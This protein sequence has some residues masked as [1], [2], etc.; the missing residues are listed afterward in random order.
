MKP[1]TSPRTT[2]SQ[3]LRERAAMAQAGRRPPAASRRRRHP[4][5]RGSGC[6]GFGRGSPARPRWPRRLHCSRG[7]LL[8]AGGDVGGGALAASP[9]L[10]W[11]L[12]TAA[13][14]PSPPLLPLSLLHTAAA[15]ACRS[16]TFLRG[17]RAPHSGGRRCPVRTGEVTAPPSSLRKETIFLGLHRAAPRRSP[18]DGP[19]LQCPAGPRRPPTAGPRSDIGSRRR[20]GCSAGVA[21]SR[22]RTAAAGASCAVSAP[23]V[24][25][26]DTSAVPGES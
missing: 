26:N 9:R 12:V 16:A 1:S 20:I 22:P 19:G 6:G 10:R 4:S 7:K 15:L 24:L 5:R 13:A 14:G 3:G 18:V 17:F 25:L 11:H 23:D 8:R 2:L 21:A